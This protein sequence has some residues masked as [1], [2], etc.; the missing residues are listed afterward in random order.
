MVC[1][2]CNLEPD[3]M[4]RLAMHLETSGWKLASLPKGLVL[5]GEE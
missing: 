2:F 4:D 3:W 5:D 1:S